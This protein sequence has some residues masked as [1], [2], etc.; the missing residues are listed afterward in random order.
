MTCVTAGTSKSRHNTS[1]VVS[2]QKAQ[3]IGKPLLKR[4]LAGRMIMKTSRCFISFR[5]ALPVAGAFG[6][7]AACAVSARADDAALCIGVNDY[8]GLRPGASLSGCVGDAKLMA[9]K[10]KL[11]GFKPILL[12]N[13]KAT[14]SAIL[15]A[16]HDLG[17]N[18]GPNDRVVIYFAGH[19]TRN[20]DG[21]STILPADARDDNESFDIGCDEFY[22]AVK[23]L[24]GVK[25][26]LLDSCHSGGM[27]RTQD[28]LKSW[29]RFRP[30]VY[31]RTTRLNA[32]ATR[33]ASKGGGAW[34]EDDI[35]GAD[36]LKP[37]LEPNKPAAAPATTPVKPTGGKPATAKPAAPNEPVYYTAALKTQ[38]ANETEWEGVPH[39]VFTWYLSQS[40]SGGNDLW[41]DIAKGVNKKVREETEDEQQ[42]LLYPPT[43]NTAPALRLAAAPDAAPAEKPTPAKL[44]PSEL[45]SMTNADTTRLSLRRTPDVTPVLVGSKNAFE[46]KVGASGYLVLI[47]RDPK[48]EV[49]LVFPAGG[50]VDAAK[51]MPGTVRL[52]TKVN[53]YLKPDT[54]GADAVKAILFT[55]REAADKFLKSFTADGALATDGAAR[56]AWDEEE[57]APAAFYTS[58]IV[59]LIVQQ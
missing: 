56:K 11:Y 39:G 45:Y 7:L 15:A 6:M 28:G 55:S 44:S 14:R 54:P 13:E 23:A 59:T 41:Q 29:S 53:A 50:D 1:R 37:V 36:D 52:P 9:D 31:V 32:P 40:L 43:A 42:P 19:G 33:T 8:P 16:I 30:R 38:L 25:T 34:Q 12:T 17:K 4:M 51:V 35:N 26:I 47:N 58:E 21:K 49:S 48:K 18:V 24:P 57:V 2:W 20:S 5:G 27:A 3:E 22:A 10:L 46:I